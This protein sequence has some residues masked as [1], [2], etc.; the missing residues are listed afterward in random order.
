MKR[1]EKIDIFF[2]GFT[3][4]SLTF[5]IDDGNIPFDK[6]FIEIVKPCGIIG[7][8]NLCQPNRTSVEEYKALY[9]GFEIAN[10]CKFHPYAFSDSKKYII[11]DEPLDTLNSPSISGECPIIYKSE[12]ENLYSMHIESRVKPNGWVHITDAESYFKLSEESR[13]ELEGIFG[14]GKIK[15][16]VWPYCEQENEK[17]VNFLRNAGYNSIRKTGEVGATTGFALPADR[18]RWSYNATN[19]T[20]LEHMAEYENAKDDG[21][22]KFF[23]FGVH[24][25]DF[26]RDNNWCDLEEFANKYGNRPNDFY[27][28]SVSDI[29][30]YEDAVKSLDITDKTVKNPSEKTVY[31]KINGEKT[32]LLPG[33]VLNL[34]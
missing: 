5:T 32:E 6:K 27:Y 21:E 9:E 22:L 33:T 24:S 11:S 23:A 16:F 15:S 34:I 29:F 8:F 4:K 26:E 28:A 20:L 13:C 12:Y 1:N 25:Y 14:K 7:T 30:E 19:R 10:H 31:L 3:K 2:P 17:L 18:M